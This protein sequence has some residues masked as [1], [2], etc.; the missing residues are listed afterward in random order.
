MFNFKN[1]NMSRDQLCCYIT[2]SLESLPMD[3]LLLIHRII[4]CSE[5]GIE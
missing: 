2:E 4:A 1:G 3:I 5:S